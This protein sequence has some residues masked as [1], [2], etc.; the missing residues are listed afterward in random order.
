MRTRYIMGIMGVVIGLALLVALVPG[1]VLSGRPAAVA[2]APATDRDGLVQL[3]EQARQ[4]ARTLA[5]DAVLR[6]I[7]VDLAGGRHIF[8]FTDAAATYE[9]TVVAPQDAA[10]ERWEV[11]QSEH[12]KLTHPAVAARPGLDLAALRAGPLAATQAMT[13]DRP[14]CAAGGLTLFGAGDALT[15]HTFCT[16]AD[17]TIAGRL[18]GR[19]GH[20]ER[21]GGPVRPPATATP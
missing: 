7:D 19:T 1:G 21:V 8:R 13:A 16:V 6:Q 15:W 20:F 11:S 3:S 5:A 12:S 17:G 10:P 14:D 9:I 18:D 4:R 2:G